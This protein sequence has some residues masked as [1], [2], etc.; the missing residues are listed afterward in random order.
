MAFFSVEKKLQLLPLK[1]SPTYRSVLVQYKLA[2][3]CAAV[4]PTTARTCFNLHFRLFRFCF[5]SFYCCCFPP[6]FISLPCWKIVACPLSSCWSFIFFV[7]LISLRYACGR[8]MQ[9]F[10]RITHA[11]HSLPMAGQLSLLPSDYCC[12][13]FASGTATSATLGKINEI[14]CCLF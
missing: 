12:V 7:P 14:I 6:C 1:K 13:T 3:H 9:V 10:A 5:N 8:L 11:Q 2:C 4:V